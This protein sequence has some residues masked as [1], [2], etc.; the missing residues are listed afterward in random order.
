M[1]AYRR[2]WGLTLAVCILSGCGFAYPPPA[3]PDVVSKQV[4][5]P[6]EPVALLTFAQGDSAGRVVGLVHGWP[7]PHVEPSE[8]IPGG[9]FTYV[10]KFTV[11]T[12]STADSRPTAATGTRTDYFRESQ[13]V[14]Y[15]EPL[16]FSLGQEVATDT[17]SMT[18][19]YMKEGRRIAVRLNSRQTSA[20]PFTYQSHAIQP[21]GERIDAELLAGD[22]SA[23]YGGYLL[24]KIDE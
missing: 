8:G 10:G 12:R 13:H 23:D 1:R 16:S 17:L 3:A 18:F 5:S 11:T 20:R 15:A 21:P 2:W 6:H 4:F 14:S 19:S 7:F 22:Y 24:R 9:L